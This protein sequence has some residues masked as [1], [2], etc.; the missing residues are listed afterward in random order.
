MSGEG[1][2]EP[3]SKKRRPSAAV[4]IQ[5]HCRV[6]IPG[7]GSAPI[8]PVPY[9]RTLWK[10]RSRLR[11]VL[12]S[13]QMGV[14][15]ALACEAAYRAINY[16]GSTILIVSRGL[17]AAR[18]VGRYIWQSIAYD[19]KSERLPAPTY[20]NL[21]SIEWE[22]IDSRIVCLPASQD[23]ARSFSATDV[24]LDE[25]AYLPWADDI[26]QALAP[27]I[28]TGGRITVVSTPR[29]RGNLFHRSWE[30]E[31]AGWSK[32]AVHWSERPRLAPHCST[33]WP[34]MLRPLV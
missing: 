1:D 19:V 5:E 25:A 3:S 20:R 4:W 34:W 23:A 7:K 11:I 33:G 10:D 26:Y 32:H 14:S 28:S 13:R 21:T 16:P 31:E 29:G 12:K 8:R 30:E 2:V 6:V 17:S 9:Q 27:T 24:Y 22:E 15:R 18:N